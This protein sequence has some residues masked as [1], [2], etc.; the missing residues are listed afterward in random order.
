VTTVGQKKDLYHANSKGKKYS[1]GYKGKKFDPD[2]ANRKKNLAKAKVT[3]IK[4]V[5]RRK[6]N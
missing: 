5:A 1:N 6:N 4:S 3:P 2:I